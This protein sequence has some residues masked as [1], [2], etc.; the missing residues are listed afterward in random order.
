[1]TPDQLT[2]LHNHAPEPLRVPNPGGADRTLLHGSDHDGRL[3][4]VYLKDGEVHKVIYKLIHPLRDDCEIFHYAVGAEIDVH[5][6]IPSNRL[7]PEAC[8][9]EFCKALMNLGF[10]L[11]FRP[12]GRPRDYDSVKFFGHVFEE[13]LAP[14]P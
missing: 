6:L 12:F 3:H 14:R 11:S 7:S 2:A 10:K 5:E 4:H 1:M 13:G 8:D 9:F